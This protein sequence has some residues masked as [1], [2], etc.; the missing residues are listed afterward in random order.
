[1]DL[2][3]QNGRCGSA[4][5]KLVALVGVTLGIMGGGLLGFGAGTK[6]RVGGGRLEGGNLWDPQEMGTGGAGKA[7]QDRDET[8]AWIWRNR[9]RRDLPTWFIWQVGP[10]FSALKDKMTCL[11]VDF[12]PISL[13]ST[14]VLPVQSCLQHPH[15]LTL[16][17]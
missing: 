16:L 2:E 7:M 8:G 3:E 1:M 4:V 5:I 6:Q 15:Y 17:S 13:F 12:A 10:P 9:G 11:H 14:I